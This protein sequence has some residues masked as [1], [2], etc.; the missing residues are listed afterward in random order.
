M[1]KQNAQSPFKRARTNF[2]KEKKA[3]NKE[4]MEKARRQ[5]FMH[6]KTMSEAS[7]VL[8]ITPRD[9]EEFDEAVKK[10]VKLMSL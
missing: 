3:K 8:G 9:T 2:L 4:G 5:M 6:C 10:T 1:A 7:I